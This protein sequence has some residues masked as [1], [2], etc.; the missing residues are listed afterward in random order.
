MIQAS[1]KA[2]EPSLTSLRLRTIVKILENIFTIR[3]A[4]ANYLILKQKFRRILSPNIYHFNLGHE[5]YDFRPHK[6]ERVRA[7]GFEKIS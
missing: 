2:S 1:F 7:K 3:A 4:N 5:H 6:K